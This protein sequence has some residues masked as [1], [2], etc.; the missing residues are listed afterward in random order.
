MLNY[1]TER[2]VVITL[3]EKDEGGRAKV[4]ISENECYTMG[5]NRDR[6]EG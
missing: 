3:K 2:A 5:L 1:I 4:T 6:S